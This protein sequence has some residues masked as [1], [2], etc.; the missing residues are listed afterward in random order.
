MQSESLTQQWLRQNVQPYAAA[1]RVYADTDAA[2]A[3]FPSVRPK[4]DLYSSVSPNPPLP[5]RR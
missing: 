3:R 2:L 5:I 1:A 4:T